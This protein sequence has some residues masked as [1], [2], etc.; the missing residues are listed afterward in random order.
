ML[1]VSQRKLKGTER[2]F[3]KSLSIILILH[4]VKKMFFVN[5]VFYLNLNRLADSG[6][7]I[8]IINID[9]TIQSFLSIFEIFDNK[10]LLKS[11]NFVWYHIF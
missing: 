8:C 11:L 4:L 10:Q 9:K 5:F 6:L 1:A 3:A 2:F 7:N